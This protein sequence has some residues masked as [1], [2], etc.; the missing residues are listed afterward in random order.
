M[1]QH[2]RE[3]GQSTVIHVRYKKE[4]LRKIDKARKKT[5]RSVFIREKSLDYK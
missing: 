3:T 2:P 4:E 5:K 1:N